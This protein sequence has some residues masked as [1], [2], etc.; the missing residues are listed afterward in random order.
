EYAKREIGSRPS[1]QKSGESSCIG[2]DWLS[3]QNFFF[4]NRK[5]K[6]DQQNQSGAQIKPAVHFFIFIQYPGR[7]YNSVNGLQVYR[8]ICRKCCHVFEGIKSQGIGNR[9]T[10]YSKYQEVFPV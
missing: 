7:Q 5:N 8:K 9:S 1:H 2:F 10:N 4:K 3:V 6:N